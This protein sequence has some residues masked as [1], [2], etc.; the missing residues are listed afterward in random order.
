MSFNV[1]PSDEWEKADEYK[2][3]TSLLPVAAVKY[4]LEHWEFKDAAYPLKLHEK[5]SQNK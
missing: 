4:G 1:I 5:Y 3:I 2:E